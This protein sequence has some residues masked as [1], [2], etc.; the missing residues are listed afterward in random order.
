MCPKLIKSSRLTTNRK[1]VSQRGHGSH[2]L[3]VQADLKGLGDHET[4]IFQYTKYL[5]TGKTKASP[6]MANW[7]LEQKIN[8]WHFSAGKEDGLQP[9]LPPT[10]LPTPLQLYS[11]S[12][13]CHLG[14][15]IIHLQHSRWCNQHA[16]FDLTQG[17]TYSFTVDCVHAERMEREN[18][19]SST[20]VKLDS[21][22][23]LVS[24]ILISVCTFVY[25]I[26]HVSPEG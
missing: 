4:Y 14:K 12:P 3:G 16:M 9:S 6:N 18:I 10:P 5:S 1:I 22:Y 21:E 11:Q 19:D 26:R 23:Q 25:F 17:A 13:Q 8:N 15:C 7:V 20:I 2:L 24:N